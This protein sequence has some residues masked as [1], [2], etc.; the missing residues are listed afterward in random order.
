LEW[1]EQ[2]VE[3]ERVRDW[4]D[5]PSRQ[6]RIVSFG[7]ER[8]D[9][10]KLHTCG[11]SRVNPDKQERTW[12]YPLTLYLSLPPIPKISKGVTPNDSS[13]T[14]SAAIPELPSPS[15][16]PL[17]PRIPDPSPFLPLLSDSLAGFN[18]ESFLP[19]SPVAVELLVLL[20]IRLPPPPP[21][22]LPD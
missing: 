13:A 20:P 12:M 11:R 5:C 7:H 21:L 2:V 22:P 10:R 17:S 6:G 19:P 16:S 8:R 15:L 18:C 14:R 1:V 4:M 3:V 9:G